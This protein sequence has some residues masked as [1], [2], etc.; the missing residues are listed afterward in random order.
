M[1]QGQIVALLAL[2]GVALGGAFVVSSAR[3]RLAGHGADHGRD[4]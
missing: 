2:F 1:R 3:G 4:G